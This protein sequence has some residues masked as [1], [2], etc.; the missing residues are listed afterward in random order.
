MKLSALVPELSLVAGAVVGLVAGV[1]LPRR[2][3][4]VVRAL[5][6]AACVA[7][8]AATGVAMAG[9]PRII[10]HGIYAVDVGLNAARIVVLAATLLVLCLSVEHTHGHS[11]ET[12]FHVLTL[13]GA[14]GAIALAGANGLLVLMAAYLVASVP[15]YALT[16]LFKD[17]LGTE[18]SLKYY[19]LGELM[20]V[21]MLAGIAILY[22]AGQATGYTALRS[23]MGEAPRAAVAVGL[24][25]VL[26][27]L[28]F[29]AG[30]VPGHF[31]IPDV[32][33]GASTPV[34][35]FVTT[36]PKVGGL[37][38]IFRLLAVA[39]PTSSVN[40]A[41]LIAV[42]AA[43][44]MTLGN[45]AA[46]CQDTPRRL[47]GYSTVSQVGYLLV[48][49][50][51]AGD[52]GLAL[53]ALLFYLAAY[54]VTNVGAFAVVAELPRARNLADYTGLARRRP[55]LALTLVVCL[56]G[57]IGTPPTAVFVGK[58]SVFSAALDGGFAWLAVLAVVNTVASVFY[59]LRWI[60]PVFARVPA[61]GGTEALAPA[62]R[63]SAATAYLAGAASVLL[64]LASGVALPLAA[65]SLLS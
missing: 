41:L 11:R 2:R 42:V 38:A 51:V 55:W 18:A 23:A 48:A 40:W 44:S 22:A 5:A 50:A 13:L 10:G 20:G 4:W 39:L 63:W 26:A 32:T 47:L 34:A 3:Q 1:F 54:A 7:G 65:G 58:L 6:V 57:F 64:G 33:E 19:L 8:L 36:V 49:V 61:G 35:A 43:A 56:L 9:G 59:Y 37:V 31:W 27:G 46:F 14:V 29:K 15:L 12:E 28:A 53:R 21:V 62:G 60:V 24:V 25:A 45:L 16:G 52:S 17:A 30:A